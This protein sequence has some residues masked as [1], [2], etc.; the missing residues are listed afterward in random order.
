[1]T[2]K[3]GGDTPGGV[4]EPPRKF[5]RR[6]C[7]DERLDGKGMPE[8]GE[9]GG[10]HEVLASPAD[11]RLSTLSVVGPNARGVLTVSL[12]NRGTGS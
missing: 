9:G 10:E 4:V 5:V 11:Q 2:N 1:M 8:G 6:G 7:G 12:I 3:P